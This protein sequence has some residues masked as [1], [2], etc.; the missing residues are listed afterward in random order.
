MTLEPN[1]LWP[2]NHRMVP[3]EARWIASDNCS[4]PEIVLI[5]LTSNQADNG[6]GDGQTTNDIEGHEPG[7]ADFQFLLRAERSG[8]Q[9]ARIYT[10]VYAAMDSSGNTRQVSAHTIVQHD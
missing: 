7:T 6:Q 4:A 2:P 9:C 8:R 1:D 10:A 5:S 3:V